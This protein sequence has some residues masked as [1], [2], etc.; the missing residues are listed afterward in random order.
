MPRNVCWPVH[1]GHGSSDKTVVFS[2]DGWRLHPAFLAPSERQGVA[3]T[4]HALSWTETHASFRD[5]L[6]GATVPDA[7]HAWSE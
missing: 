2:L 6:S 5:L 1:G 3:L 4:W 7:V